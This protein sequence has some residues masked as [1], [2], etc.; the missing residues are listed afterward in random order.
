MEAIIKG[1]EKDFLTENSDI[2]FST[3]D[4]V[5]VSFKIQE[6][7]KSRI[8]IFEGVIIQRSGTGTGSTF[9]VRKGSGNNV[10]VE[11]IFPLHSP[12]IDDIKVIRRGKV[13]RAKIFY[14]RGR[15]GKSAR[16]KER[17]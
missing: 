11:R 13:R 2:D 4:T 6:G 8:Q 15:T 10:F 5:A 3:G 12:L 14:M 16:L 1:V 9:T 7:A 17:K